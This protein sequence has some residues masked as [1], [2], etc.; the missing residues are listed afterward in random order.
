MPHRQG[1]RCQRLSQ[2]PRFWIGRS[3]VF[4]EYYSG[5][6]N[7]LLD[8][9]CL[10]SKEIRRRQNLLRISRFSSLSSM[11]PKSSMP[12]KLCLIG[13]DSRHH[14]KL[15]QRRSP[16]SRRK[17]TRKPRKLIPGGLVLGGQPARTSGAACR[18]DQCHWRVS[19]PVSPA[20]GRVNQ[21]YGEAHLSGTNIHNYGME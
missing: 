7:P 15:L 12:C 3:R 5:A 18:P 20:M 9:L 11:L 16:P 2:I 4:W 13:K 8:K 6:K 1:H 14:Q 10:I 21:G 17:I 19:W